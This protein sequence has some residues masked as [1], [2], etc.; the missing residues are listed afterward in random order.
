VLDLAKVVGVEYF[1]L[2]EFGADGD[3]EAAEPAAAGQAPRVP[4]RDLP[5]HGVEP[6]RPGDNRGVLGVPARARTT[7]AGSGG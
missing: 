6:Q 3:G 2:L 7:W 1:A 4:D 5:V